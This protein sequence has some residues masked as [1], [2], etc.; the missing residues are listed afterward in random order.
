MQIALSSANINDNLMMKNRA[1]SLSVL[2]S[3]VLGSVLGSKPLNVDIIGIGVPVL[4]SKPLNVRHIA[5]MLCF[6]Q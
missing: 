1:G 3:P 5:A 4:G 6:N 2:G